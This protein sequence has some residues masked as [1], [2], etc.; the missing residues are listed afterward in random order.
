MSLNQTELKETE[1]DQCC[2]PEQ[3]KR[4]RGAGA[5]TYRDRLTLLES[6]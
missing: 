5:V 1:I 3:I 6:V 4:E 2:P